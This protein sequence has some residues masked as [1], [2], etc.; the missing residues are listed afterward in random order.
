[1]PWFTQVDSLSHID[2]P[3]LVVHYHQDAPLVAKLVLVRVSLDH[4]PRNAGDCAGKFVA[5]LV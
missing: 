3:V 4:A 1:M 2:R 5:F